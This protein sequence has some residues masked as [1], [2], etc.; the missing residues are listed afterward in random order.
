MVCLRPLMALPITVSHTV[1]M[2]QVRPYLSKAFLSSS[3][4]RCNTILENVEPI[5][6]KKKDSENSEFNTAT[7]GKKIKPK[8]PSIVVLNLKQSGLLRRRKVLPISK[9]SDKD[10]RLSAFEGVDLQAEHIGNYLPLKPLQMIKAQG[11]KLLIFENKVSLEQAAKS[12]Q[13]LKPVDEVISQQRFDELTKHLDSAYT[14]VQLRAY[15][16]KFFNKSNAHLTKERLI[17]RIIMEYWHCKVDDKAL[18]KD[19]LINESVIDL[20]PKALFLLLVTDNSKIFHNFANMGARIIVAVDENKIIVN[21]TVNVIRYIELALGKILNNI[22]TKVFPIDDILKTHSINGATPLDEK[23]LDSILSSIERE[24]CVYFEKIPTEE[25]DSST[26]NLYISAVG[27]KRLTLA[28]ALFLSSLNFQPQL[29]TNLKCYKLHTD[30]EYKEYPY[31]NSE[32]LIWST[33]NIPWKRLQSTKGNNSSTSEENRITTTDIITKNDVKEIYNALVLPEQD[34]NGAPIIPIKENYPSHALFSV[35]MGQ[36]L[37]ANSDLMKR[38]LFTPQIPFIAS[39]LVKNKYPLFDTIDSIDEY[40]NVDHHSYYVKLKFIPENPQSLNN[41]YNYPPLEIWLELDANNNVI[42]ISCR[43]F[44]L[45]AQR[46]YVLQT[47]DFPTDYRFEHDKT[48]DLCGIYE[49]EGNKWLEDQPSLKAFINDQNLSFKG[50]TFSF[51]KKLSINIPSFNT[52]ENKYDVNSIN[53]NFTE[54]EHHKVVQLKHNKDYLIQYSEIKRD[55]LGGWYSQV[56]FVGGSSL[57]ENQFETFFH[58]IVH[59]L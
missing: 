45:L 58:D 15:T 52:S 40:Y 28:T 30:N 41:N 50:K 55:I 13:Y 10:N 7:R 57:N 49:Y 59:N 23:H 8:T 48:L 20:E 26:R 38:Q 3:T 9:H 27:A 25:G 16:R 4:V 37:V 19:K 54:L 21:A 42:P 36:V 14:I 32:N 47:P 31:S 33:K 5:E 12:I 43:A 29:T 17:K 46:H 18:Q 35:T 22:S 39:T 56:D 24:N 34:S 44:L 51:K 6:L 2:F 11:K 1:K 53:Y